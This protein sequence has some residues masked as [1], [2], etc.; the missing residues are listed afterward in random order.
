MASAADDPDLE[1]VLALQSGDEGALSELMRRHE[2]AL[3]R[4]LYRYVLNAADAADLAQE[5]FVRAYFKIHQFQPGA[6][7]SV[8]LYRIALNLARDHARSRTTRQAGLTFE[9]PGEGRQTPQ[10]TDSVLADTVTPDPSGALEN[11][12][13]MRALEAAIDTLPAD[14][15]QAFI[16][17]ALEGRSQKD[18]GEILG[19]SPKAVETR[20][21]RARK[22]LAG[23][24]RHLWP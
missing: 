23:K 15:K 4:F 1:H 5:T 14:L 7:F 11:K 6:K 19:T 24:L 22:L 12:E 2:E 20:V 10:K 18:C 8:W 21:Y 16:L 3:F 9:L 13:E 17:T